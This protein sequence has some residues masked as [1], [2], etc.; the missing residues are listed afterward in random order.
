VRRVDEG[1]H[2][3]LGDVALDQLDAHLRIVSRR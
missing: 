1:V 3:L 2:P